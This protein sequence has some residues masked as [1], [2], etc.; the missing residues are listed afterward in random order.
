VI[1]EEID[2][3]KSSYG[4]AG[5]LRNFSSHYERTAEFFRM[6]EM[7]TDRGPTP[8]RQAVCESDAYHRMCAAIMCAF[9]HCDVNRAAVNVYRWANRRSRAESVIVINHNSGCYRDYRCIICGSV[10]GSHSTKYPR[11][12]QSVR[13]EENHVAFEVGQIRKLVQAILEVPNAKD[14]LRKSGTAICSGRD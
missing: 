13:A 14:V 5:A 6:K 8:L 3:S 11:T 2:L 1:T 7:L 4:F 10:F 12:K 9:L